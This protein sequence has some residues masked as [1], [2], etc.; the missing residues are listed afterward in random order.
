MCES[1]CEVIIS[2]QAPSPTGLSIELAHHD[3]I[4]QQCSRKGTAAC[5]L[6]ALAKMVPSCTRSRSCR[7]FIFF[8]KYERL[9]RRL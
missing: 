5:R 8:N 9:N 2:Y 4:L 6:F 7:D 1:T 3:R